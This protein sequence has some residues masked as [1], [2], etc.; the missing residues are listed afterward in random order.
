MTRIDAQGPC[1]EIPISNPTD[2]NSS[3]RIVSTPSEAPVGRRVGF[4]W[5]VLVL[6]LCVIPVI[7]VGV[8]VTS[9][10][11]H[12]VV[13]G[14]ATVSVVGVFTLAV[15]LKF[16]P[17][18]ASLKNAIEDLG[19]DEAIFQAINSPIALSGYGVIART[20]RAAVAS[21][22]RGVLYRFLPST[23]LG[24]IEPI[25]VPFEPIVLDES[26]L[27]LVELMNETSGGS[28]SPAPQSK[29][30]IRRAGGWIIV[31]IFGFN[32]VIHLFRSIAMRRVT[33][34]LFYWSVLFLCMYFGVGRSWMLGTFLAV[35]GGLVTRKLRG[36]RRHVSLHVYTAADSALCVYRATKNLWIISVAD[37]ENAQWT[38]CAPAE[39]RFAMAAWTSPIAPPT[40]EQL[41]EL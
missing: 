13:T 18:V 37:G 17:T 33:W 16:N 12:P 23:E 10:D 11:A 24:A 30:N 15:Y 29:R 40:M 7:V 31:A 32:V 22:H 6:V 28:A 34:E 2:S 1:D 39:A 3:V 19:P 9:L 20:L 25:R 35:P 8:L 5:I 27:R 38:T 4:R 14:I 26:D 41:S 36:I 21:G